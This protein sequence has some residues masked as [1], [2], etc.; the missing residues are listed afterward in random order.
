MKL[1]LSIVCVFLVTAMGK[2]RS[3]TSH[4]HG[5]SA[6]FL[7]VP[8]ADHTAGSEAPLL[9]MIALA[10][11]P[12]AGGG[13]GKSGVKRSSELREDNSTQRKASG[14]HE[15]KWKAESKGTKQ[16]RDAVKR[17]APWMTHRVRSFIYAFIFYAII[18]CFFGKLLMLVVTL[19][20]EFVAIRQ[21]GPDSTRYN[22]DKTFRLFLQY[23]FSYWFA[24]TEGSRG[25][26]LSIVTI[27]VLF[28]GAFLYNFFTHHTIVVSIWNSFVWLVAPDAGASENT[29]AGALIGALMSILGLVIFALLLT[30]LQDGFAS[31]LESQGTGPI[32]DSQHTILIGLTETTIPIIQQLCA[33]Y[34]YAGGTTIVV[35]TEC[36]KEDL[37]TK[38]SEVVDFL[39]SRVVVRTGKAWEQ[40]DLQQVAADSARTILVM[41]DHNLS[42]E[43]R[44][45]S[46]LQV[47]VS[48]RSL[49][50]P[51]QGKIVAVCSLL[52]NYA[53]FARLG[54]TS[55]EVVLLDRFSAK[56][57]V[58]CSAVQGIAA[59]V[60]STL[61]FTGSELYIK[62]VPSH[63]QGV[64]FSKAATSYPKAVLVGYVRDVGGKS[65][66]RFCPGNDY[67]LNGDEDLV[68]I[69]ESFSHTDPLLTPLP[70][71]S[72]AISVRA[73]PRIDAAPATSDPAPETIIIIGWN[74]IMSFML[75]ELDVVVPPGTKVHILAPKDAGEREQHLVFS[76]KRS[77]QDLSHITLI[78]HTEGILGS[79]YA[80]DDFAVL[81]EAT[82]IFILSDETAECA[83]HADRCTVAT[84]LQ[85]RDIF[86]HNNMP[87]NIPII[88]EIMDPKTSL[89]C[90]AIGSL[91]FMDSSSLP[92][93][94]LAM[95]AY[96][97]RIVH[98]LVEFLSE[99]GHVTF[100][101]VK[102]DSY[103]EEGEEVESPISF[104]QATAL[105]TSKST[106]VV[107]AWSVPDDE[108]EA[109]HN[110]AAAGNKGEFHSMMADWCQTVHPE[111]PMREWELNPID[112]YAKRTWTENDRLVVLSTKSHTD[113]RSHTLWNSVRN[114]VR[115]PSWILK[116]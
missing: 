84:V 113:T 48:L 77:N 14:E 81:M 6:K 71:E 7:A 112:K 76:H 57:M 32:V 97:P 94:L 10:Q 2:A 20:R 105:V 101:I 54:G 60:S 39:G 34:Q 90:A 44:D 75:L 56:L 107:I 74:E 87:A 15:E 31:Y 18:A 109:A 104:W 27:S 1:L 41:A 19:F 115:R 50:W 38:I 70:K 91:D 110:K 108:T 30:L 33:A 73:S 72:G 99:A 24:W 98:A 35:L 45:A 28:F 25:V 85:I 42:K 111:M 5:S 83:A 80:L 68:L 36:G 51:A 79:R 106:D 17:F 58:Q 8:A 11:K 40:A 4:L 9:P 67:L 86:Y 88:P 103:V 47:L 66:T 89:Q 116:P 64:T 114:D 65:E 49:G 13:G 55:T 23:R 62:P 92:S 22:K 26:V 78:E 96:E 82:R 100:Q 43:Q 102:L 63:M 52:R 12:H 95:I 3:H 16:L 59:A 29:I 37:E 46:A 21:A 61:G 53:L 93:Q 69:A